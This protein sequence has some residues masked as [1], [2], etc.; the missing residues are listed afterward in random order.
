MLSVMEETVPQVYEVWVDYPSPP[1]K[2]WVTRAAFGFDV[3][4][5]VVL[6]VIIVHDL[7]HAA[8]SS[9]KHEGMRDL[10]QCFVARARA[11]SR[12]SALL[13]ECITTNF[14]L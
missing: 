8:Y 2:P 12:H 11:L 3:A 1:M 10:R 6:Q 9:F 7:L 5:D 14:N 13:Q 4:E